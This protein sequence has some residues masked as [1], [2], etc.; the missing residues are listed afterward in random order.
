MADVPEGQ[1]VV[2]AVGDE[3]ALVHEERQEED[4]WRE[5]GAAVRRAAQWRAAEDRGVDGGGRGGRG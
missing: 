1:G 4:G 2:V 3:G 5:A